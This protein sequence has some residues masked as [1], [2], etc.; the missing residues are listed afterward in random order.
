MVKEGRAD[1]ELDGD[2]IGRLAGVTWNRQVSDK[3]EWRGDGWA[4]PFSCIG[5]RG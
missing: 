2:E 1:R 3:D 5:L 4:R